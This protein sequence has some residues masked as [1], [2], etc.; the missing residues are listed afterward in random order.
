MSMLWVHAIL[1]IRESEAG[2]THRV[3]EDFRWHTQKALVQLRPCGLAHGGAPPAIGES[4]NKPPS[5]ENTVQRHRRIPLPGSI[6]LSDTTTLRRINIGL[7]VAS[8]NEYLR[9]LGFPG[10]LPY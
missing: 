10:S 8:A 4:K 1:A 5:L 6:V 9:Y 7:W 2:V 3:A